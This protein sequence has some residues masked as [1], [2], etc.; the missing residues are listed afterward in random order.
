MST[1][2]ASVGTTFAT[3]GLASK[4]VPPGVVVAPIATMSASVHSSCGSVGPMHT[5]GTLAH[6][7]HTKAASEGLLAD[8]DLLCCT[9]LMS[10]RLTHPS[11]AS[12]HTIDSNEQSDSSSTLNGA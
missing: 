8:R 4:H 5:S 3:G 7:V 11:R 9:Q 1:V 6:T 2:L 10:P 12:V